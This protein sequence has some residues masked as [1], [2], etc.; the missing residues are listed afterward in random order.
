MSKRILWVR[1]F[2]LMLLVNLQ[3]LFITASYGQIPNGYYND[4]GGLDGEELRT[5]LSQIIDNHSVIQYTGLWS[6]FSQTDKDP[7]GNIIDIYSNVPGGTPSIQ[8]QYSTDQCGNY[9]QEGDCYNREHTVPQDWFNGA[10][11]MYS[12]LFHIYPT[13]GYTNG[14]RANFAYGEVGSASWTSSNGSKVGSCNYPGC[15]GTVFEPIDEYKGDLARAYFYM[16]TRYKNQISSWNSSMFSGNTFSNWSLEMLLEWHEQ[17]SVSQREIDRNNAIYFA[18]KNRNPFVDSTNYVDYIWKGITA[19]P[20]GI[21]EL[22]HQFEL[23]YVDNALV[24]NH[25]SHQSMNERIQVFSIIGVELINMPIQSSQ[26]RIPFSN[27]SGIYLVKI[28]NST[29]K[30]W[31]KGS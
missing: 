19:P 26:M 10:S 2:V 20:V 23:T 13:D 15:S 22:V 31:V 8:F 6:R 29:K 5:A 21:E 25:L 12:D 24:I 1:A 4:A 11:P 17:D 16:I 3:L 9:S 14:K 18:Q 28:G 7:N 27:E 30:V